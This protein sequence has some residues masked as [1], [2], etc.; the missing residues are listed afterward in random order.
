MRFGVLSE[1]LLEIN[2]FV[3]VTLFTIHRLNI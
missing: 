1:E 3:G 2:F